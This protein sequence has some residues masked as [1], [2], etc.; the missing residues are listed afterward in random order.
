MRGII[1]GFV[2][3]GHIALMS[4]IIISTT[5]DLTEIPTTKPTPTAPTTTC[6][7]VQHETLQP[8]L[9]P[10]ST[11][12]TL[13]TTMQRPTVQMTH[14]SH[15]KHTSHHLHHPILSNI[16][17]T[18]LAPP[19]TQPTQ[20][21]RW[22]PS[23]VIAKKKFKTNTHRSSDNHVDSHIRQSYS[24]STSTQSSQ[25]NI[26]YTFV[27]VHYILNIPQHQHFLTLLDSGSTVSWFNSN[28]IPPHCQPSRITPLTGTTMAGT[29]SSTHAPRIWSQSPP[30]ND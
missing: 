2:M 6:A 25:E 1:H 27:A 22:P 24:S 30:S 10:P 12:S 7:H 19:Y 21:Q 15:R 11:C 20:P 16:Q 18:Q 8:I 13:V 9:R 29:F 5:V 23:V 14:T 17:P 26:P 4:L 28:N 3:N